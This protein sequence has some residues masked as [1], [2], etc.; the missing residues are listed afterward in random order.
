MSY[1]NHYLM[2]QTKPQQD[3]Q[4]AFTTVVDEDGTVSFVNGHRLQQQREFFHNVIEDEHRRMREE[5]AL[6]DA[7]IAEQEARRLAAKDATA[8]AHADGHKNTINPVTVDAYSGQELVN[9]GGRL[10]SKEQAG[11]NKIYRSDWI[12]VWGMDL[13]PDFDNFRLDWPFHHAE[14]N[15]T[16]DM[17]AY[18]WF[19]RHGINPEITKDSDFEFE[20]LHSHYTDAQLREKWRLRG[21]DSWIDYGADVA[22]ALIPLG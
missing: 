6:V 19:H 20:E 8:R 13:A 18:H 14:R 12:D 15:K 11:E 21:G 1:D 2:L 16:I 3:F 7:V 4:Q 10:V 17:R 5:E 22:D 9:V